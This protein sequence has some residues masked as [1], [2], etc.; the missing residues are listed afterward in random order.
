VVCYIHERKGRGEGL[1]ERAAWCVTYMRGKGGERGWVREG[2][3]VGG[4]VGG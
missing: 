1:G 3:M 4:R 2:Q